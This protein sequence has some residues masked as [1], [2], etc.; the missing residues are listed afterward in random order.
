MQPL[1]SLQTDGTYVSAPS[2]T[3][4]FWPFRELRPERGLHSRIP[5]FSLFAKEPLILNFRRFALRNNPRRRAALV[6][7]RAAEVF[8]SRVLLSGAPAAE[9]VEE[10]AEPVPAAGPVF[11]DGDPGEIP[12]E[13]PGEI[14]PEGPGEIPGESPGEEPGGDFP[15][16]EVSI[17][18]ITELVK[19]VE[20][21]VVTITGQVAS[22][23][24]GDEI[25]FNIDGSD[26]G[27]VTVDANGS[28]SF[29]FAYPSDFVIIV[30]AFDADGIEGETRI[31][32]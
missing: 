27:S 8:E 22:L 11:A 29:S 26:V 21:G 5:S 4:R 16:E 6:L 9:V 13:G 10:A 15:G 7:P 1:F 24:G 19:T 32:I 31:L 2:W 3:G 28:F 30:T 14:P 17:T 18:R 23:T 25:V 12:L 20:N